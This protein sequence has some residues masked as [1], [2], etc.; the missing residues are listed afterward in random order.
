MKIEQILKTFPRHTSCQAESA[1]CCKNRLAVYFKPSRA[2][3]VS[4]KLLKGAVVRLSISQ[5]SSRIAAIMSCGHIVTP[6]QPYQVE[7]RIHFVPNTCNLKKKKKTQKRKD[8]FLPPMHWLR[9]NIQPLSIDSPTI[10]SDVM[11]H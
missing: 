11:Q 2:R 1:L 5:K 7:S 8:F 10:L 6:T 3:D 9:I 4:G